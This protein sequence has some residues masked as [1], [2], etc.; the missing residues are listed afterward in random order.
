MLFIIFIVDGRNDNTDVQ[1]ELMV[2]VK[3]L[4]Q[5]IN[6]VIKYTMILSTVSILQ[7]S[8]V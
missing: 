4:S 8:D 3:F 1:S 6:W 5:S 7:S 2:I